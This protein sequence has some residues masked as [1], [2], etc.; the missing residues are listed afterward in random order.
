MQAV[1]LEGCGGDRTDGGD[2][3]PVEQPVQF[4]LVAGVEH[5]EEIGHGGTAGEGHQVDGAALQL[6]AQFL[7]AALGRH[8]PVD[9]CHRHRGAGVGEGLRQQ[10]AGLQGARQEDAAAGNLRLHERLGKALAGEFLRDQVDPDAVAEQFLG[11]RLAHRGNLRTGQVPA[12]QAEQGKPLEEITD[13]VQAGEQHPL[14]VAHAVDGLVEQ[15]V[16]IH[17][18]DMDGRV[19]EALGPVFLQLHGEFARLFPGSGDHDAAAEQ[20]PFLEPVDGVAQLD[21][22]ADDHQRGRLD[23]CLLDHVADG[24]QGT[25][26]RMLLRGRG[27]ADHGHRRV[28]G[29]AVVDELAGDGRQGL[30]AHVDDDGA[31][32]GGQLVPGDVGQLLVRVLVAGDERHRGRVFTVG[33]GDAGVGGRG[34]GRGHPGD[35][36]EVDALGHQFLDLLGAPAEDERVAALQ[37]DD[38]LAELGVLHEQFVDAVLGKGVQTATFLAGIDELRV[39]RHVVEQ[40][41]AGEIV[42]DDHL[43]VLEQ[44][45]A[46]QGDESG[47]TRAGADEVDFAGALW[48]RR[49]GYGHWSGPFAV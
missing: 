3:H 9:R 48:R 6:L 14:V 49:S 2:G 35:D 37:P 28:R 4:V 7:L 16:V 21:H 45:F 32:A 31:D 41:G 10:V 12:V 34:R 5:G 1:L 17:R 20:G 19:L 44:V 18:L 8:V 15:R 23:V 30:D 26:H 46:A 33:D 36:L 11:G 47:I 42:V 29:A 13:R 25:D 22:L 40:L 39:F 24:C 27:P 38:H 43:G